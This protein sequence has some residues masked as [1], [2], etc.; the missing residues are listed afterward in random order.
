MPYLRLRQICLLA[1]ELE[2]V[3]ANL[4]HVFGLQVCHRDPGVAKY[5]LHNAL[6][7]V[8][9]CFVEVVAPLPGTAGADTAA[10][11]HLARRRGDSGYMVILDCND[12]GPWREY[13]GNQG[14]REAAF[15]Q[16]PDSTGEGGGVAYFGLQLHPRDTGGALLEINHTPGGDNLN[17]AYWPAGPHWQQAADSSFG[18][19]LSGITLFS[20]VPQELAQRWSAILRS[21][22]NGLAARPA[23]D[24]RTGDSPAGSHAR[25]LTLDNALLLGFAPMDGLRGEG[26][27][28][29][30]LNIPGLTLDGLFARAATC[31][32]DLDKQGHAVKI[33]GVW[34]KKSDQGRSELF[35]QQRIHAS[36]VTRCQ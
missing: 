3:V 22:L 29:V 18:T 21:P 17:G 33:G 36:E 8:G 19:T 5:G 6:M 16:V 25:M 31:G 12:I 28:Q 23:P 15:L 14:V 10:T 9:S 32:C 35:H 2:P 27:A 26:L 34:W 30:E 13:I 11:R 24:G 1:R 20:D 7:R 4:C